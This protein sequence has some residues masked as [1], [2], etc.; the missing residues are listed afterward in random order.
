MR[1]AG[2]RE[3]PEHRDKFGHWAGLDDLYD[4]VDHWLTMYGFAA[5][6][7]TYKRTLGLGDIKSF[8][9]VYES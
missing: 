7:E 3:H 9:A 2:K 4:D 5:Y 1:N 8:E 6:S